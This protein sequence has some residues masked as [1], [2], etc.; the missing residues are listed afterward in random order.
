M[1]GAARRATLALAIV[2]TTAALAGH[3]GPGGASAERTASWGAG[4]SADANAGLGYWTQSRAGGAWQHRTLWG[5]PLGIVEAPL[6]ARAVNNEASPVGAL[7]ESDLPGNHFCTASVVQSPG[8]DLLITAAHCVNDGRGHNRSD[9]V[10][11]PGYVDGMVPHGVWS[12]R[13]VIVDPRW[14][15]GANPDYDVGFVVLYP[16]NGKNI[17]DVLGAYQ[18]GFN[19]AYT[20]QVWVTGYPA[21]AS[22]PVTCKNWT[23]KQSATQLRFACGGFYRGTSGSPWVAPHGIVGVI[24]GYQRGGNTPAVSYSPYLGTAIEKLYAQA[25]AA[26]SL[27]LLAPVP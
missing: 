20:N 27:A 24:G 21:T 15:H 12:L 6:T 7:F 26:G 9:I 16:K 17:Q 11:V 8:R 2:L 3:D 5:L 10:F 25:K 4:G 1:I 19:D 23:T 18:I 22:A 14:A 13:Q